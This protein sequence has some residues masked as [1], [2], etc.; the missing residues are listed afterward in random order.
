MSSKT[1]VANKTIW[2]C[3]DILARCVQADRALA[4]AIARAKERMDPVL[5][6]SL[7]E[8][9]SALAAVQVL[10][11]DARHGQYRGGGPDE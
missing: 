2:A 11:G 4:A 1:R 7:A 10:A 8:A 9:R 6:L 3:E 5:L